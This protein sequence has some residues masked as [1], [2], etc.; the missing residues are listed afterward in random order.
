MWPNTGSEFWWNVEF[1]KQPTVRAVENPAETR[2]L[3]A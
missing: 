1:A 2:G 3:G